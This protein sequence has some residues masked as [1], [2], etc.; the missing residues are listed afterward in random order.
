MWSAKSPPLVSTEASVV[1]GASVVVVVVVMG[2]AGPKPPICELTQVAET[3]I[4]MKSFKRI[5]SAA[6]ALR[7]VQVSNSG[8]KLIKWLCES[9]FLYSSVLL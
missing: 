5:L 3:A 1:V 9:S 2:L 4:K 6:K 8:N 7:Y